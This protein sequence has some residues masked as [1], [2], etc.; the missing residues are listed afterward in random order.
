MSSQYAGAQVAQALCERAPRPAAAPRSA[1]PTEEAV[2]R[3]DNAHD[4]LHSIIGELIK[5]LDD[6]GVLGGDDAVAK[7]ASPS[8]LSA[9]ATHQLPSRLGD[10]ASRTG[11]AIG[12]IR[13]TLDRLLV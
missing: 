11:E 6:G 3:L 8:G 5:R 10:V 4:E 9:L 7:A 13:G 1:T 2:H 12:R